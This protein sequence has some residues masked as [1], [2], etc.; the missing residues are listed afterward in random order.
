MRI[1]LPLFI[2]FFL[3]VA[4]FGCSNSGSMTNSTS[5]DLPASTD[6][7]LF[8]N[9]Y[10]VIA[11]GTMNLSDGTVEP[12][13]RTVDPYMNITGFIGSNFSY[14]IIGL[15]P[16]PFVWEIRLN[17]TNPTAMTVHDVCIVFENTFGKKVQNEDS[18][19][20]IWGPGD[21]DPYIIFR[22]EDPIRAFPPGPDTEL[23]F[24]EWPAGVPANVQ[25]FIIA[26]FGGNTGSV[27]QFDN[28]WWGGQLTIGGGLVDYHIDVVDWQNDIN[29]VIADTTPITGGLT[30]FTQDLV[31]PLTWDANITN[32]V[33][34]PVGAYSCPIGATSPSS[35]GYMTYSYI[36]LEVFP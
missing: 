29:Y 31:N 26:H 6:E 7:A 33:G 16:P 20:D 3:L 32:S 24:L 25:Y 4:F 17:L 18:Y 22:K 23:L 30:W 1:F 13:F 8:S 5:A 27:S 34:A 12:D 9:D 11:S 28:R 36:D 15:N 21:L 10:Q 19:M 35:P 14:T 2:L